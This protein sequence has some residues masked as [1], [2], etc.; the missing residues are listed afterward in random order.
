MH[1]RSVSSGVSI[2]K[3][4]IVPVPYTDV[5]LLD[6]EKYRSNLKE[7]LSSS[8]S[9]QQQSYVQATPL[10]GPGG[11]RPWYAG[12]TTR[13]LYDRLSETDEIHNLSKITSRA[14]KRNRVRSIIIYQIPCLYLSTAEKHSQLKSFETTLIQDVRSVN[15]N[16]INQKNLSGRTKIYSDIPVKICGVTH[17]KYSAPQNVGTREEKTL[18]REFQA[19][20]GWR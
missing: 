3:K 14:S 2:L 10:T 8:G 4:Y 15:P 18:G 9:P 20:M 7:I 19:T 12:I 5:G 6:V 11:N 13:S 17:G 16:S 1:P